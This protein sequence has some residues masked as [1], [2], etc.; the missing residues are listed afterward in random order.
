MA[1]GGGLRS[2]PPN[3]GLVGAGSIAAGA[4]AG[5]AVGGAVGTRQAAA[6]AAGTRLAAGSSAGATEA[7]Q[8]TKG[9]VH[10]N[11]KA[12]GAYVAGT[13]SA[14]GDGSG[15]A[16]ASAEQ[17]M[18]FTQLKFSPGINS[19]IA[20][21]AAVRELIMSSIGMSPLLG[22]ALTSALT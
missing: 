10:A 19:P 7:L 22:T 4:G 16:L 21:P 20:K 13:S 11:G 3:G 5:M 6:G 14:L 8:V 17:A 2:P 12:A 18:K 1:R 9:Q 15:E